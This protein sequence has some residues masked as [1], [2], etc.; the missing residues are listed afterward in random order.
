MKTVILNGQEIT[1]GTQLRFIDDRNL[2]PDNRDIIKIPELGEIY[3][4]RGF[5]DIGGI[6]IEEIKNQDI[7]FVNSAG[8]TDNISEPGF[9]IRRFEP[10]QTLSKKKSIAK[11]KIVQIE[12]L[13]VVEERLE[14]VKKRKPILN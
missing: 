10:A 9:S 14:I 7:N 1:I 5:N 8:K 12:I 6:Y 13:P 11:K 2:Y 4:V 3:T